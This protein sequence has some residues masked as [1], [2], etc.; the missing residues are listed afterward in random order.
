MCI[1]DSLA[2]SDDAEGP[3][4]VAAP[5]PVRQ[6]EFAKTVAGV[7]HRPAVVPTPL[8]GPKAVLGAQATEELVAASHRVDVGKLLASG[9]RF[10]N[11]DLRSCAE[12]ILGRTR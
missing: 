11:E 2:L 4:N 1:R 8:A 12:H 7:L 10:R 9:Y 3:F 6:K 5:E